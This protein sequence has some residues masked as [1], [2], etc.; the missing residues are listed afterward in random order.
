MV[1]SGAIYFYGI[2]VKDI[3]NLFKFLRTFITIRQDVELVI[4]LAQKF[5]KDNV[6]YNFPKDIINLIFS[7]V[8][9]ES[10]EDD[11]NIYDYSGSLSKILWLHGYK[12]IE[13]LPNPYHYQGFY[14]GFKLGEID[15]PYRD[16]VEEFDTFN[17][18]IKNNF[19]SI[20][21]RYRTYK[22][23]YENTFKQ[24]RKKLI[25]YLEE[26]LTD[27]ENLEV[28]DGE[29]ICES[30][31]L[32][33]EINESEISYEIGEYNLEFHPKFLKFNNDCDCCS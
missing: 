25:K 11:N 30:D 9:E 22:K 6:W 26:N 10:I 18:L 17:E 32:Y 8:E 29:R 24:I 27:P 23:L 5:Q 13:I 14:F 19:S 15:F 12:M 28:N 3:R 4:R 20:E 16:D 1:A 2:Y 33:Y 21:T 7:M 31:S